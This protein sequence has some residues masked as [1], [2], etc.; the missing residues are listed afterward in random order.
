MVVYRSNSPPPFGE[1][2]L[3]PDDP[4]PYPCPYRHDHHPNPVLDLS[5]V[6]PSLGG[7]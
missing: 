4:D 6:V 3:D 1:D 5:H 2:D 7:R